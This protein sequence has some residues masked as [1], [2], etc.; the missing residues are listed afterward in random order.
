MMKILACTFK[1]LK[2]PGV[3]LKATQGKYNHIGST[4][5]RIGM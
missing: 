2:G 3:I 5:A 1:L 4:H